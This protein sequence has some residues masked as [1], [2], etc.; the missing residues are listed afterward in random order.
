MWRCENVEMWECGKC[1]DVRMWE[2]WRSSE[3]YEDFT[4]IGENKNESS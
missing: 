2:M 3:I 4:G 1:G